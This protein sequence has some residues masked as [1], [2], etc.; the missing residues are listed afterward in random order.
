[1]TPTKGI[2]S[3][4]ELSEHSLSWYKEGNIKADDKEL[5]VVLNQICRSLSRHSNLVVDRT[6]HQSLE[7]NN[8]SSPSAYLIPEL[9]DKVPVLQVQ[10]Q[11]L[12]RFEIPLGW[13][14]EYPACRYEFRCRLFSIHR[15]QSFQESFR[16]LADFLSEKRGNHL[17]LRLTFIQYP[18]P[19]VSASQRSPKNDSKA[20][21]SMAV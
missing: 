3:I 19:A 1:M 9:I 2:K 14:A 5:Q 20:A 8:G 12:N 13:L 7:A 17:S 18:I 11:V 6:N 10:H 16:V 4:K 15:E 21:V